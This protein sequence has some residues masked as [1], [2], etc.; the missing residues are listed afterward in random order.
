MINAKHILF[1]AL[2][3]IFSCVGS[4]NTFVD[5]TVKLKCQYQQYACDPCAQY[6]V[7]EVYTPEF[8]YL[9]NK[10]IFI[11]NQEF[12]KDTISQIDTNISLTEPF[13]I[14]GKVYQKKYRSDIYQPKDTYKVMIQK[15][16][17]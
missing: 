2:L 17:K 3:L 8:D 5:G 14:I 11:D 10:V 16:V 6:L 1:V 12:L 15:I 7:L 9:V 13:I 4:E